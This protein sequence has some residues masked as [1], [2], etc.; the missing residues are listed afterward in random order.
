MVHQAVDPHA[1]NF[2]GLSH[3]EQPCGFSG[4]SK[5]ILKI[6]YFIAC[7]FGGLEC[8]PIRDAILAISGRL[9]PKMFGP[10]VPVYLTE[11]ME[12]RGRPAYSGP[13]DGAGRRSIYQEVRRNFL[14]PMMRA[15]DFPVPFTT[16]GRRTVSNVPAQSLI[17]MNDPFV[18]GQAQTWAN[19][20]LARQDRTPEQRITVMYETIFSRPPTAHEL[21]EAMAFLDRQAETYGLSSL[22]LRSDQ[23]L[24]ADLCQVLMN[25]KEFIFVN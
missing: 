17:L 13:L 16:V 21:A 7:R 20:L 23:A 9:D 22:Q 15:F 14:S 19:S 11:F 25:V 5:W 8:E 3:V 18:V 2:T 10:P 1:R 24:W 4:R 12:G 6:Y